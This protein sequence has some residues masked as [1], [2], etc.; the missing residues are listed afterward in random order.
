MHFCIY[1]FFLY[2]NLWYFEVFSD[3]CLSNYLCS[4]PASPHPSALPK[5]SSFISWEI[6]PILL[7]VTCIIV[8][9]Y[10]FWVFEI[11]FSLGISPSYTPHPC[12]C[13]TNPQA[14]QFKRLSCI[15]TSLSIAVSCLLEYC[16]IFHFPF[17]VRP[18]QAWHL[19][20]N[21]VGRLWK[22]RKRFAPSSSH[23]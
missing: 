6:I 2:F 18:S 17:S 11:S 23:F 4:G 20:L 16:T 15:A 13:L 22:I 7:K 9:A 5:L 12:F 1:H 21:Q 10:I 8:C 3:C 19:N 14:K